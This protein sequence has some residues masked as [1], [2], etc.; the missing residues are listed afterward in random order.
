MLTANDRL[1]KQAKKVAKEV[2]KMN[3]TVKQAAQE[4]L[5]KLRKDGSKRIEEGR[6]KMRRAE[7]GVV[8]FIQ[9]RPLRSTL[10][11]LGVGF[12]FAGVWFRRLT[13]ARARTKSAA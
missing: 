3:G 10:I 6:G 4:K 2:H 11:A 13:M 1:R 7:R 8:R 12:V 5:R 9:E